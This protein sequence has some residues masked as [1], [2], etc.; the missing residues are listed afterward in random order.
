MQK[1][2]F[3]QLVSLETFKNKYANKFATYYTSAGRFA[4]PL[5]VGPVVYFSM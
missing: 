5:I 3:R 4:H 2:L 1:S